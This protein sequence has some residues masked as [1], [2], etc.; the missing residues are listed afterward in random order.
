MNY[1]IK[2]TIVNANNKIH[3]LM[4]CFSL[5]I[6]QIWACTSRCSGDII[7]VSFNNISNSASFSNHS[8]PFALVSILSF[9]SSSCLTKTS[10]KLVVLS[11]AFPFL[12]DLAFPFAAYWP[13]ECTL[14]TSSL[15]P[16][17]VSATVVYAPFSSFLV[18]FNDLQMGK[19]G[20]HFRSSLSITQMY[21]YVKYFFRLW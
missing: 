17:L 19:T 11:F 12:L 21:L 7:E 10:V 4:P 2:N 9:N 3:H 14:T 13:I 15:T 8:W 1:T 6:A 20:C 16:T 5:M 18:L